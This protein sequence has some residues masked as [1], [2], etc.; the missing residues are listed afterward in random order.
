VT[1]FWKT[2]LVHTFLDFEKYKFEILKI[3]KLLM[4]DSSH[5]TFAAEIGIG[6]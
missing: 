6:I 3:Y 2:V 1:W 4:L 5:V